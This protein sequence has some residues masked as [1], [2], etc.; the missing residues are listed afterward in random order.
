MLAAFTCDGAVL[1]RDMDPSETALKRGVWIDLLDATE[2]EAR[3][4]TAAIGVHV[5]TKAD[6]SEIESS[7]RLSVTDNVLTLSMPLVVRV[8]GELRPVPGGFVLSRERLITVR[9]AASVVFDT[10]V[11]REVRGRTPD[12]TGAHIFVG[13]LEAIIDRQADALEEIRAILDTL[14]RRIFHQSMG[15][16]GSKREDRMLR[17]TLAA[18]GRAGDAISFIRDTQLGAARIVPYVLSTADEWLPQD[19]VPRLDT[20]R[21][22]IGSLKDFD[23]HLFEKVQFLLDATLGFIS[24]AQN[25]VMKVLTVASVVGIP[26]VL[27]A[28]VYG[29]NFKNMPELDWAWGYTYGLVAIAVS[30]LVPLAWFKLRDWL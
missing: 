7:S 8:D 11:E 12:R 3:R 1:H 2:D 25:N 29:M 30:A 4:V 15:A 17:E 28:G 10:F 19:L 22:D 6:L 23:T 9:F 14:S 5:P 18:V 27:V 24:I 16:G 20:L 21:Q 26:P 13:L